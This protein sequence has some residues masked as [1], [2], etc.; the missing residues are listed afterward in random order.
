MKQNT[1]WGRKS[2]RSV[3]T[4]RGKL[5]SAKLLGVVVWCKHLVQISPE[6]SFQ[7]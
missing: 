1:G 2:Q 7:S 3:V 5:G 6:G 4:A